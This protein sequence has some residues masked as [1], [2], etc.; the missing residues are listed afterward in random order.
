[1]PTNSKSPHILLLNPWIH[2]FSAYD[3]WAKPLGL[4]IAA[5]WLEQAG[6]AIDYLDLTD[7]MSSHLPAA[8]RPRRKP[9]GHGK[10]HREKISRPAQLPDVNRKFCRYGLPPEAAVK[11]LSALDR[12][13]FIF[14]TSMMTY[15]YTGVIET[16]AMVKA[17]W[18]GVPV[19]LGGVYA[20]LCTEHARIHSGADLVL[21]GPFEN[22]LERV[23][24]FIGCALPR[25]DPTEMLPAHRLIAGADSAAF[26]TSRGCPFDCVYCGVKKLYPHYVKYPMERVMREIRYLALELKIADQALFDDAFLLE[27][28]RALALLHEMAQI[29]APLRLHA[30]SGLSC[31][32]IT[33]EVARAMHG[34]GFTTIRLGLETADQQRHT[35]LGGKLRLDEFYAAVDNLLQAGYASSEIGVYVMVGM[36]GQSR[37]EVEMT[38]NELS[39]L[40]LQPHLSEYSPVPGS[41]L[42]GEATK[43]SRYD[44][45]EPLCHNPTLLLCATSELSRKII[46]K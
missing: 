31:K 20:T 1:M 12:P 29:G 7:P 8:L 35:E 13:D 45:S 19:A 23:E 46:L 44:L 42:F 6:C 16:I 34:A 14:V 30:A 38:L 39:R 28:E 24:A 2:D 41:P 9:G 4:L 32:G 37:S 5:G 43:A 33:A 26:L 15:W 27:T 10:F 36:P 17:H 11:A 22:N 21:P 3:F 40:G 18:P 25:M